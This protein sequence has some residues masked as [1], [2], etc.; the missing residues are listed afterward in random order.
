M[1]QRRDVVIARPGRLQSRSSLAHTVAMT[2]L[3][4]WAPKDPLGEALHVLRMNGA[5][6]CRSELRAPWGLALPAMKGYMWFHVV[7][8]GRCWLEAD[9]AE[10]LL[11][12]PGAFALVP[13]GEGHFLRS[14][15]TDPALPY[16]CTAAR[17]VS[18]T[19]DRSPAR[20]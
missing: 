20:A 1:T 12:E 2:D 14:E 6:Y 17:A 16:R 18:A 4:P 5:Y 9:G 8:Q 15:P 7:T 11:I 19:W 3:D 10:Q 13:H